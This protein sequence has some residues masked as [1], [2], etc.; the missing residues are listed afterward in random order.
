MGFFLW[1]L[2]SIL[3]TFFNVIGFVFMVVESLLFFK[4]RSGAKKLNDYFYQIALSKDQNS[5]VVLQNFFNK[6]MLK[7]KAYKFGDPDETI[8]FVFAV[9]K[10]LGTLTLFGGFWALF[11]DLFERSKGGHLYHTL[12]MK[13]KSMKEEAEK[14]DVE[15]YMTMEE[16]KNSLVRNFYEE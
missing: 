9:N 11:L 5:N 2:A 12:F 1:I 3:T 6:T 14:F 15:F 8:S 16:F 10:I 7:R 13:L 4:W